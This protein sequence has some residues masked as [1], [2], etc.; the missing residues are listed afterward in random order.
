M[1]L[2]DSDYNFYGRREILDLLNKRVRGLRDGYRQNLA[3][4]GSRHVGKTALLKRFISNFEDKDVIVLYLD[5]E[6]RDFS[7]FVQQF[8]KTILY[9]FLKSQNLP[10]HEDLKLL[11]ES[12]RLSIPA[13][14]AEIESIQNLLKEGK[15]NEVYA[16]LLN[17]SDVFYGE[18]KKSL[19]LIFDEFQNLENFPLTDVYVELGKR[20]MTQKNCLY[21]T[22]SSNQEQARDIFSE[23]LSLLFGNFEIV[24]ILPFDLATSQGLIDHNLEGIKIGLYLKN[25][26]A[27]FTGGYPLYINMLCQE[28]ICLTALY[29]QEEIYAPIITQAIENLVFNPWGV[30]S[31]HFELT[32][33][34]LRKGKPSLSLCSLLVALSEGKHRIVDAAQYLNLKPTGVTQRINNLLEADVVEKN[35]NY[36]HIKDKLFRYWIKYVYQ[37]RVKAIDLEPGRGRKSFKEEINRCVNEFQMVARKDLSLRIMDLLHKFDEEDFELGGRR[38]KLNAFKDVSQLKLRLGAGNFL[39]ALLASSSEGQW[40]IVLKKDPILDHD[41]SSLAEEIKKLSPRPGRC[42]LISLSGLDE[43]AKVRALQEKWWIWNEAQV[44]TLMHLY[45][46]PYLIK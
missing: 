39:D 8:S 19:V 18:T 20:I 41:L 29:R 33:S 21:I 31:R 17:L 13:T 44:N 12:C 37:R 38:Y 2:T 4:L 45:D 27:D 3:L 43:S 46:E 22:T 30:I 15:N 26:L 6:S 24:E 16:S 1:S 40:L 42:V 34:D 11:C 28:L 23:K 35:G 10:L 9:H 36:Y 25:F 14:T 7:Y 5:L 32:V